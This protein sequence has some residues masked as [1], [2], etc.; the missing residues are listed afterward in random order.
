MPSPLAQQKI[1]ATATPIRLKPFRSV[2][3]VKL[4]EIHFGNVIILAHELLIVG[5]VGTDISHSG[6]EV[7]C[8]LIYN[9]LSG[10][11]LKKL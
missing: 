3:V 6:F 4:H 9:G 1:F 2:F 7:A 8:T 10:F 11:A 5:I